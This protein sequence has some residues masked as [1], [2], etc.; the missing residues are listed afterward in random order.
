MDLV[1]YV[2]NVLKL[3]L[4]EPQKEMLREYEKRAP[5]CYLIM[6]PNVGYKEILSLMVIAQALMF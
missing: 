5:N 4:L 3:R 1:E 6:P 2:E